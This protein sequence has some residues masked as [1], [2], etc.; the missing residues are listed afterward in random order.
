MRANDA[1]RK[2]GKKVAQAHVRERGERVPA[3]GSGTRP[4]AGTPLVGQPTGVV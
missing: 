4:A 1:V 2:Y 3:T